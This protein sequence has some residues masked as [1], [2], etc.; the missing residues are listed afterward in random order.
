M[1]MP[2]CSPPIARCLAAAL[3]A[4]PRGEADPPAQPPPPAPDAGPDQ[5]VAVGGTAALVGTIHNRSPLDF[6]VGDGN[7]IYENQLVHYDDATGIRGVGPLVRP[8][9]EYLGWPGDLERIEGRVYGIDVGARCVY[10]VDLATGT[11]VPVTPKLDERYSGL[12]SLAYDA[13]HDRLFS[14]DLNSAQLVEI[15]RGT[16][17]ITPIPSEDLR[18]LKGLR[19]LA[20]DDELE[21]LFAAD[22]GSDVL[23]VIDPEGGTLADT[24]KLPAGSST[25]IEELT[26]FQGELYAMTGMIKGPDVLDGGQLQRIDLRSGYVQNIGPVIPS[27]SGHA[28]LINSVPEDFYWKQVAGPATADLEYATKLETSARFEVPGRYE[29]E[30][31]LLCASGRVA[32]R[33]VVDV[34]AGDAE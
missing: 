12:H 15:E 3:L 7:G 19:S 23:Y 1:G 11:C 6:W 18:G 9:G 5:V 27:V 29:F 14:I 8:N 2:I 28:L 30:L 20:F 22:Y 24:M 16:G 4:L 17:K 13:K 26:F 34:R 32:D 25:R 21:L 10:A 33:V 31:T